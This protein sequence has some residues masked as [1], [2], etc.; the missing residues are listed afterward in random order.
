MLLQCKILLYDKMY[1]LFNFILF[2][3]NLL[4]L[5]EGLKKMSIIFIL[6]FNPSLIIKCN[7]KHYLLLLLMHDMLL[8]QSEFPNNSVNLRTID[9]I[10]YPK[11]VLKLPKCQV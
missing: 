3:V 7:V 2:T 10:Q 1:G 5:R 4:L 9:N 6:F 11:K 8:I